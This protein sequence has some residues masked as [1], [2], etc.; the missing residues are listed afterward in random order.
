MLAGEPG[1]GKSQLSAFLAAIVTTHG[2]WPNG[3]GRAELGSVI[4]L[5]A[6]DDAA[7]TIVPRLSAA[8]AELSRVHIVSAVTTDDHN[9]RRLFNLQSDLSALEETIAHVGDVRLVIID[10]VSSYLGKIDSHKNAEVR[11]VLEPIGEMASRLRVA[12]V[13]VTH[14]S[15]GGG[16]SANNRIIGSI[17]FVAAARAAFIVSRDPDDD[18]RRLFVSS[19]NNL[20]P[21]RAGLAFRM[22]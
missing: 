7:D 14:F 3:E 6:E 12:V 15:K 11:T 20:G 10:P 22:R 4:V 16:T 17:A 19:K 5:S 8:G 18:S 1:L 21:D 9:G 13:A 2:H